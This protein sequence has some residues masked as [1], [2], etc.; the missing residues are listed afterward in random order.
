MFKFNKLFTLRVT[1]PSLILS[2]R[3]YYVDMMKALAIMLMVIGHNEFAYW[4]G[5]LPRRIIFSFHM[6][7][8]F[9]LSGYMHKQ[10]NFKKTLKQG[11][12]GLLYPYFT[13]G[14]V[15][16]LLKILLR[17]YPI[18]LAIKVL[19]SAN[20]AHTYSV[21][22]V[23]GHTIG[24][25][26]FLASLFWA[27]L[28]FTILLSVGNNR[29]VLVSFILSGIAVFLASIVNLPFGILTGTSALFFLSIGYYIKKN[30]MNCLF[31]LLCIILW[32]ITIM[33][34]PMDMAGFLYG[35]YLLNTIGAIG[36]T[37][38]CFFLS[39]LMSKIPLV[40]NFAFWGR[41]SLHVLCWHYLIIAIF[42]FGVVTGKLFCSL[43]V[44]SPFLISYFTVKLS[45]L[46]FMFTPSW[47]KR[48][49]N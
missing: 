4:F 24:P 27:R 17:D 1:P 25:I 30:G 39:I 35:N 3:D 45:I 49:I 22:Y 6:P 44:I 32:P 20:S 31:L 37:I 18:I 47:A 16:M 11:A 12:Y 7:L 15:S 48:N 14:I 26:W 33:K 2:N 5:G 29:Y 9:I 42:P 34:Y 38:F 28:F 36:G 21:P 40:R 19:F 41:Y 10:R 13:F 46:T 23:G 8:F 43:F